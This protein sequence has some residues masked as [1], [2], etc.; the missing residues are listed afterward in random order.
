M[1][2]TGGL[3]DRKSTGCFKHADGFKQAVGGM[4]GTPVAQSPA[5]DRRAHSQGPAL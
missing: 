5:Q 1:V 3:V 2:K 4:A